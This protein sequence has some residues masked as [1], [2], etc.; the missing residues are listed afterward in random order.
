MMEG[1]V[2]DLVQTIYNEDMSVLGVSLPDIQPKA[3]DHIN[4]MI[5]LINLLIQNN[6]AYEKEGHVLFDVPKFKNYGKLSGQNKTTNWSQIA[7]HHHAASNAK[8]Y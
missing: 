4:E 8:L 5:E 7:L 1:L 3:T 2:P 6:F